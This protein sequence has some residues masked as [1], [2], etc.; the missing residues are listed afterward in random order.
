MRENEP[1]QLFR[2]LLPLLKAN[3]VGGPIR[4]FFESLHA[5]EIVS[6]IPELFPELDANRITEMT[7]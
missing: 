2:C 7:L 3:E 5:S 6:L 4:K 1:A